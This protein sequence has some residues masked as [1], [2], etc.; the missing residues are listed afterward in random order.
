MKLLGKF[1]SAPDPPGIDNQRWI[2]LIGEHTNLVAP[3]PFKMVSSVMR[4]P[5]LNQ[6]TK[7]PWFRKPSPIGPQPKS[8]GAGCLLSQKEE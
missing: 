1:S 8:T 3:K 4:K 7:K 5:V 2:D 6:A